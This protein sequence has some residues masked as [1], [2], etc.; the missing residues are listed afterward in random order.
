MSATSSSL[1][2]TPSSLCL[3]D[4]QQYEPKFSERELSSTLSS[5]EQ[6]E[7]FDAIATVLAFRAE[8]ETIGKAMVGVCQ[9][10]ASVFLPPSS[11]TLPLPLSEA[12]S[13][14]K[15]FNRWAD[16]SFYLM[17]AESAWKE[18]KEEEL[19][20]LEIKRRYQKLLKRGILTPK[21]IRGY[22]DSK[23]CGSDPFELQRRFGLE[24]F[25]YYKSEELSRFH[26]AF[27]ERVQESREGI[28]QAVD[29]YKE[30][31]SVLK[32]PK[33]PA[34]RALL[35]RE[36]LES[37]DFDD[38]I[39]RNGEK[40][41]CFLDL[42]Q[43]QIVRG[44]FLIKL[45]EKALSMKELG[46]YKGCFEPLEV[47]LREIR[48]AHL[49]KQIALLESGQMTYP[50]FREQNPPLCHEQESFYCE[51]RLR[52]HLHHGPGYLMKNFAPELKLHFTKEGREALLR[53]AEERLKS[54]VLS[55]LERGGEH[56]SFSL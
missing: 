11:K 34:I 3:G 42:R 13:T 1:L 24:A 18:M 36:V 14:E 8:E 40:R 54:K 43:R 17:Q 31:G 44:L 16:R 29:R 26:Q 4:G 39:G 50:Q 47:D 27:V 35:N 41:L 52:T 12:L 37:S 20:I 19:S 22:L 51:L 23:Y 9:V 21:D 10:A 5:S 38:F 49:Q 7:F 15:D 45:E 2:T 55:C 6:E 56:S 28:C 46:R 33:E 30:L 53:E 48:L 25:D 32:A